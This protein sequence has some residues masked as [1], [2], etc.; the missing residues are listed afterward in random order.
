KRIAV[1]VPLWREH[2]V[3]RHMIEHNLMSNRYGP[4]DFFVGAYP[5]DDATLSAVRLLETRFPNVHL[6]VCSHAG[7][8]SKADNLN[9]IFERMLEFE[10][11]HDTRF[12]V[13]VTH[14]AEDQMH[15]EAL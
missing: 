10:I 3:I 7:P 11:S 12:E 13:V 5:N 6:S 4:Y 1:F 2:N 8:T 15:P 14:D 9:W